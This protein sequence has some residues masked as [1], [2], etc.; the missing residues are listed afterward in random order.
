MIR[1]EYH[2]AKKE[3]KPGDRMYLQT[4]EGLEKNNCQL[5][6]IEGDQVFMTDGSHYHYREIYC[7]VHAE[8]NITR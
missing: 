3:L 6:K 4:K 7:M 5:F 1:E 8:N 2:R